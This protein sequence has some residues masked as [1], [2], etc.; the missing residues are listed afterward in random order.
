MLHFFCIFHDRGLRLLLRSHEEDFA[1]LLGDIFH[2]SV[3][4]LDTLH[5]LLQIN[6]VDPVPGGKDKL[7]HLRVPPPRLVAKMDTGFQQRFHRYY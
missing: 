1:V 6:N 5:G 4:D 2:R 7:R 3:G